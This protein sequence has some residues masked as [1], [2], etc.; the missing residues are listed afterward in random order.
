[1]S[2]ASCRPPPPTAASPPNC[3]STIPRTSPTSGGDGS[4]DSTGWSCTTASTAAILDTADWDFLDEAAPPPTA[5]ACGARPGNREHGLYELTLRLYQ[6][7]GYDIS[8]ISLVEGESG[9]IVIDPL[10]STETAGRPWISC[11]S[12]S[13]TAR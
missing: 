8:N 6:V 10:T 13:V 3:R 12:T 11:A 2:S 4:P 1:M 5:R 7:R 9:W